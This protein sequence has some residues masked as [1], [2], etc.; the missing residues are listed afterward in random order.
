[1]QSKEQNKANAEK[2]IKQLLNY[3]GQGHIGAG[4]WVL[5]P[6]LTI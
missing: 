6:P 1:M 5:C 2:I 4:G 3:V